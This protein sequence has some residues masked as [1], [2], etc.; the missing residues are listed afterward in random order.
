MVAARAL[1]HKPDRDLAGAER[2]G[3]Q[4]SLDVQYAPWCMPKAV[5]GSDEPGSQG[6]QS[7]QGALVPRARSLAQDSMQRRRRETG[8]I[9]A[10]Y[11]KRSSTNKPAR[12]CEDDRSGR[13]SVC[14][15]RLD[16]DLRGSK[17][18]SSGQRTAWRTA[19]RA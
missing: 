6:V 5:H 9:S 13:G 3:K 18:S 19:G 16:P 7:S 8:F 4:V 2:V 15:G 17:C 12:V 14:W 11:G 10:Q 1:V